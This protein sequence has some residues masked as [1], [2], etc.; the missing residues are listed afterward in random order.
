MKTQKAGALRAKF[1]AGL[2]IAGQTIDGELEFIGTREQWRKAY[3]LEK[4]YEVDDREYDSAR[5]AEGLERRAEESLYRG[6]TH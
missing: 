3:Q 6:F 2:A 4:Y 5:D 1:D